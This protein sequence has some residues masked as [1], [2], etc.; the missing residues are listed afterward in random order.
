MLFVFRRFV[1]ERFG[2]KNKLPPGAA[3]KIELAMLE[4]KSPQRR[5]GSHVPTS[6]V[7]PD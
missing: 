3:N 6:T 2:L 5:S 1:M 4:K 7:T